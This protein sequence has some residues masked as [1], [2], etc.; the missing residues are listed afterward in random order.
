M[1]TPTPGQ[2]RTAKARATRTQAKHRRWAEEMQAVGWLPVPPTHSALN[3]S[4]QQYQALASAVA[5]AEDE[6]EDRRT[7]SVQVLLR[8]WDKIREDYHRATR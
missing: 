5:L 4:D 3:L 6:W 7:G 2:S 8:A 1:T